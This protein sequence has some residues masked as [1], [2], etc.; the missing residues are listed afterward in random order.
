MKYSFKQITIP[1]KNK[2]GEIELPNGAI[3]LEAK[4][5]TTLVSHGENYRVWS[6]HYLEPLI[7]RGSK[8]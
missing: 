1:D 6:I 3:I 8:K 5:S 2:A 4:S 7:R